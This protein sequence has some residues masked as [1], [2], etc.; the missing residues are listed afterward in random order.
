MSQATGPS[1]FR[2]SLADWKVFFFWVSLYG[3]DLDTLVLYEDML[4]DVIIC[5]EILHWLMD[6]ILFCWLCEKRCNL[7]SWCAVK[8][9][10][11]GVQTTATEDARALM[12]SAGLNSWS[13]TG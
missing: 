9:E 12:D 4:F 13:A 11:A 7:K 2:G 5:I 1:G 3:V 10:L 8:A 6:A